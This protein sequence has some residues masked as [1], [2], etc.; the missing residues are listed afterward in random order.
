MFPRDISNHFECIY[1]GIDSLLATVLSSKNDDAN[2]EKIEEIQLEINKYIN[3]IQQCLQEDCCDKKMIIK[4]SAYLQM[5]KD[6]FGE[7]QA[8]G[9]H[10]Y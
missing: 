2:E 3:G 7:L 5:T 8:L 9:K 1:Q 10:F 6:Y 4:V